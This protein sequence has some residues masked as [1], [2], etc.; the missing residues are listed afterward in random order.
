[1]IIEKTNDWDKRDL[2]RALQNKKIPAGAVL[3]GKELLFDPH[4]NERNFFEVAEHHE[5]TE[6]PP[7]PYG[8]RPWKFSETPGRILS[9]IHI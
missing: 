3:D 5:S 9:L 7:L 6:M 2:E 4:L 1:M 8:T